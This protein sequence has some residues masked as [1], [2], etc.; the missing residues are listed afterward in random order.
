MSEQV[1][2][3]CVLSVGQR[4]EETD[5]RDVRFGLFRTFLKIRINRRKRKME[6]AVKMYKNTKCVFIR[7]MK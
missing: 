2:D 7:C 4:G 5:R 1:Q 3:S 6:A